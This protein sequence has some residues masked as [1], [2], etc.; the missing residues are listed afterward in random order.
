MKLDAKG[1]ASKVLGSGWLK[2][3]SLPVRERWRSVGVFSV[4]AAV[5]AATR[6]SASLCLWV[7]GSHCFSPA[8]G[9]SGS[10]LFCMDR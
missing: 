2:T 6:L 10:S 8:S 3:R 1:H 7:S 5:S 4:S 9:P